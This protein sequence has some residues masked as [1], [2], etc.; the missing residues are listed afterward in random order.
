MTVILKNLYSK[1]SET[2]LLYFDTSALALTTNTGT[3]VVCIWQ[4]W[5][6]LW[7]PSMFLRIVVGICP[8]TLTQCV[9]CASRGGEWQHARPSY[10]AVT[11]VDC[12]R[13]QCVK[14]CVCCSSVSGFELPP[15]E[16]QML[17]NLSLVYK[18][19]RVTHLI[20]WLLNKTIT[21]KLISLNIF[22]PANLSNQR[23]SSSQLWN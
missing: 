4:V 21:F 22:K 8:F 6:L 11:G 18:S 10:L 1:S 19:V 9:V 17:V 15:T 14:V 23:K 3:A 12:G 13:M 2:E 16:H 5:F 7:Y 20:G